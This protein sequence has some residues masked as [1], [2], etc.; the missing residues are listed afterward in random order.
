MH[1]ARTT[2]VLGEVLVETDQ[3]E[4]ERRAVGCAPK[5]A[6]CASIECMLVNEWRYGWLGE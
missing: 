3:I 1:A 4:P 5:A 6:A 2:L